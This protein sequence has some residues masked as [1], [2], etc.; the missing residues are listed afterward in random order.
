MLVNKKVTRKSAIK[1][2]NARVR[3]H[4]AIRAA[5]E[6]EMIEDVD[7]DVEGNGGVDVAPE[8]SDLLFE[9]EDVAELI[10]EVTGKDVAVTAD[11]DKVKFEVGDEEFTV[12]A[13]GDEE[14]LEN[15][16]KALKGKKPV[17]ASRRVA[18]RGAARRV[19]RR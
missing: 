19:V 14:I 2:S 11:E 5:E 16:R 8:A 12:E 7:V 3:R 13:D 15:T 6:D 18:S 17:R 9:A 10:A 4:R 1:A